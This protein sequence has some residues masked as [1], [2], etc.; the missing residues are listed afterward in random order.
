M[1]VTPAVYLDHFNECSQA[2]L[3]GKFLFMIT[4]VTIVTI[5]I[6]VT[7]YIVTMVTIVIRLSL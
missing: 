1:F 2:S 7:I 6:K 3:L 5:I 4:M